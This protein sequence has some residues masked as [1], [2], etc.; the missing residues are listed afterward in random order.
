MKK[1]NFLFGA[2]QFFYWM[3]FCLVVSFSTMFLQEV[4]FSNAELGIVIALANLFGF[5]VGTVLDSLTDKF[6]KVHATS[7]LCAVLILQVLCQGI[8]IFYHQKGITVAV[9][10]CLYAV[11]TYASSA[12]YLKVV[13]DIQYMGEK[14][15]YSVCRGFGSLGYVFFS[16]IGGVLAEQRSVFFL[17][18][19]GIFV[20]LVQVT[21][22]VFM[23]VSFAKLC[24]NRSESLKEGERTSSLMEF[25]KKYPYF[26]LS[27]LGMT[28]T[29][30][31]HN[32][33]SNY[34]INIVESVGGD[35][36]TMGFLNGEV[37]LVEIPTLF[38]YVKLFGK[39]DK[40]RVLILAFLVTVMKGFAITIA[41]NVPVLFAVHV[42]QAL[43][44]PLYAAAIVDY[45]NEVIPYK[46]A[47]KGQSLAY[48]ASCLGAIMAGLIGGPLFDR[49][50]SHMTMLIT[51]FTASVGLCLVILG[52]T[53]GAKRL[54]RE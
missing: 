46:D 24:A 30:F 11:C 15:N 12:V 13:T 32:T 47:G 50:S 5:A 40:G 16:T 51:A 23:A 45:V 18:E 20:L 25:V 10:Y 22:A 42:L 49:L 39:R 33:G 53:K 36:S 52:I 14:I 31:T 27:L 19:V 4:G 41:W 43:A 7:L 17:H 9:I 2:G 35:A 34:L 3:A 38:L 6:E 28:L 1:W 8:L 44:F 48:G 21:V 54:E 29:L 37:A 26:M